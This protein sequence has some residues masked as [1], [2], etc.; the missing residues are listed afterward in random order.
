MAKCVTLAKHL[1]SLPPLGFWDAL[2]LCYQIT[3]QRMPAMYDGCGEP[4]SMEH[5]IDYKRVAWA[6]DAEV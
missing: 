4:M 3:L 5:A 6:C 2:S 1:F